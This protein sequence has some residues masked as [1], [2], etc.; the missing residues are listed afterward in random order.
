MLTKAGVTREED[1]SRIP[2][3]Y[4]VLCIIHKQD[5]LIMGIDLNSI[6][7]EGKELNSFAQLLRRTPVVSPGCLSLLSSKASLNVALQVGKPPVTVKGF[8]L[9]FLIG[10]SY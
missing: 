1:L 5:N 9:G 7:I 8:C 10:Q 4:R 2:Q 6:T 3:Q